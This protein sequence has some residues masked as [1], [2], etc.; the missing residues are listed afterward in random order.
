MTA[1]NMQSIHIAKVV[2]DDVDFLQSWMPRLIANTV[3]SD[4]THLAEISENVLGNL[5]WW[6]AN[7]EK[8]CHLKSISDGRLVGVILV[9]NFWNLCSLFV[10][11][12]YQRRGIGRSLVQAAV[13]VCQGKNDKNALWLNAAPDAIHFYTRLGFVERPTMQAL[14]PEFKAMILA[15]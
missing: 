3:T 15:L 6:Q 12:A 10:D 11:P 14:P 13:T 8:C 1:C 9:K 7:P 2:D 4:E 5:A